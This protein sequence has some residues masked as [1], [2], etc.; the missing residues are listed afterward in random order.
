MHTPLLLILSVLSTPTQGQPD[1]F[2]LESP[3]QANAVEESRPAVIDGVL[4]E[5]DDESYLIRVVG[6]EVRLPKA[7][8]VKIEKDNLTAAKIDRAE[9]EQREQ[10]A[11]AAAAA[12]AASE[13][14]A[15]AE[16]PTAPA[17][18]SDPAA[19]LGY[20]EQFVEATP[21]AAPQYDPVLHVQRCGQCADDYTL[22][23][24]LEMAYR[25]THDRSLRKPLRIMRRLR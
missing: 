19:D 18:P 12:A 16:A 23:R 3:A 24:D 17:Q 6:G 25:M 8:V 20:V 21:A 4:L 11:A 14:Q 10:R 5:Q 7:S 15:A 13:Q 9:R 22:L 1:K 2:W